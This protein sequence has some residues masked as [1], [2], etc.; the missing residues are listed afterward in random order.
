MVYGDVKPMSL[1]DKRKILAGLQQEAKQHLAFRWET[2]S[3]TPFGALAEPDLATEFTA[4][5]SAPERDDASQSFT[6]CVLD[7]LNEGEP[8]PELVAT[9]KAVVVDDSRWSGIRR[10]ALSAWLKLSPP[11]EE[12]IALLSSINDQRI[13]DS[14]DELAG[15]L[16]SH[17]YPEHIAPYVLLRYLHAPKKRDYIGKH[18]MFWGYELARIAPDSHLPIL[19]DQLAAR[20]DLE[21]SDEI[22]LSFDS[23]RMLEACS[24]EVSKF[25]AT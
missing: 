5:L 14:D 21:V 3:T 16:L 2:P 18:S 4:T 19:L 7:I 17:L 13:T 15:N 1:A 9:I 24:A 10:H 22:E 12:A 25:M 11:I 23:R 6:D 8:I 20:T